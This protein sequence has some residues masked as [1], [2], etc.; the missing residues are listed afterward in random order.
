MRSW[1]S[2]KVRLSITTLGVCVAMLWS[3]FFYGYQLVKKDSERL[4]GEQQFATAQIAAELINDT[5]TRQFSALEHAAIEIPPE[6]LIKR[7]RLQEWLE[8]Q[9]SLLSLF[10]GGVYVT[11]NR[12]V[13]LAVFPYSRKM[14]ETSY[15]DQSSLR[16]P[17]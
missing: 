8:G 11:G 3:L 16:V 15:A 2:L 5:V 17:A 14:T 10:N 13:P 7:D 12:G 6:L 4:I 9:P 1:Q